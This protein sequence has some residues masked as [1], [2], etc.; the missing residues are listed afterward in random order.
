MSAEQIA[1]RVTEPQR[2]AMLAK[3][4]TARVDRSLVRLG[5]VYWATGRHGKQLL[6]FRPLGLQVRA[7]LE[8]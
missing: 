3:H 5:L 1:A 6:K 8:Q 2:H 7:L 4:W